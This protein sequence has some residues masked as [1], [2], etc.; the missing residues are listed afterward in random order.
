MAAPAVPAGP[1]VGEPAP[2]FALPNLAGKPVNLSDFRGNRTLLLFWNPGCGFCQ[3]MLDDLKDWEVHPP[4]G[5]PRLL[6]VSTGTV[7]AN[8]APG[9]RSTIVLDQNMSVGSKFGANGT[10]MAVLVDGQGRIASELAVGAPA[11]M[12]LAGAGKDKS[13]II[14]V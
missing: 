6:V 11:V 9:L 1:K 3:R 7:E 5:A 12:T 2:S 10:P 8:Q 14:S 13:N 4:K